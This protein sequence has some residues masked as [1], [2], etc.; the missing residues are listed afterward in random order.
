MVVWSGSRAMVA[1]REVARVHT[2]D[3]EMDTVMDVSSQ[4]LDLRLSYG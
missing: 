3:T 2:Q 4:S 1:G